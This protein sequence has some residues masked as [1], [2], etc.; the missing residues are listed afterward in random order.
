MSVARGVR[1]IVGSLRRRLSGRPWQGVQTDTHMVRMG[2][3][4]GGYCVC[5]EGLDGDSIVYSFGIGEDIS[6][7]LAMIERFSVTIHAF[8]PT[9]RS[10]E[11]V[12]AQEV[13]KLVLKEYGLADY[14][15]SADFTPPDNP[16]H[17]SHTLL[18]RAKATR[19][20]VP[21]EVRRLSTITREL[22]HKRIDVLKMDIEGAEYGVIDDL[23]A[24]QIPIRQILMEFHHHL[25]GVP[26]LRTERAIA[27]L[28]RAG[29]RIFDTSSSG[30]EFS[31]IHGRESRR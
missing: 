9:P 6:F 21:V 12:R 30:H 11:W 24:G 20:A 8:D 13:E 29:Y 25:P 18:P 28:N 4:Y 26:L 3:D 31:F 1:Q 23:L 15:G 10:I 27:K 5:P 19:P 22:G 17:I 2:N 16:S 14:D 7:D